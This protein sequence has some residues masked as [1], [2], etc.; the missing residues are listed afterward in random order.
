MTVCLFEGVE[1]LQVVGRG[2]GDQR[3]GKGKKV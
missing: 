2:D 1:A 3:E